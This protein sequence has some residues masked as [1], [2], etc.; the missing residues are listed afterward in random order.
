[1]ASFRPQRPPAGAL[2]GASGSGAAGAAAAATGATGAAGAAGALAVPALAVP[3]DLALSV[4][5]PNALPAVNSFLKYI[6]AVD[7]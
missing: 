5:P 6:P 7:P 2:T 4:R 1:V 3:A